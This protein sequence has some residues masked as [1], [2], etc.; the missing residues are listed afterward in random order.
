M[1]LSVA[2]SL[3]TTSNGCRY[4]EYQENVSKTTCGGLQTVR[5]EPKITQA[6]ELKECAERC[7]VRLYLL[8]N[9]VCPV[10]RPPGAFYLHPLIKYTKMQW[11]STAAVAVN[12][13]S[14]AVSRIARKPALV[15]FFK[16]FSASDRGYSAV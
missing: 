11:Y 8:Y 2:E 6:F 13:L 12:M 5:S 3:K 7:P 9:S 15:D 10:I 4:L 1:L 16:S 14:T